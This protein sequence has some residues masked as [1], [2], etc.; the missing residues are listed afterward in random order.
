VL[1]DIAKE[2]L[3]GVSVA[4]NR[5][6]ADG[7]LCDEASLEEVLQEHGEGDLMRSHEEISC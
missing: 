6:G 3:E 7:T 4:R 1:L 2:E 5:V